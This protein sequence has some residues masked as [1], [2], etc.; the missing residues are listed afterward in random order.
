MVLMVLHDSLA[1]VGLPKFLLNLGLWVGN[2]TANQYSYGDFVMVCN[3][4]YFDRFFYTCDCW[5]CWLL[6]GTDLWNGNHVFDPGICGFSKLLCTTDERVASCAGHYF[7]VWSY[8]WQCTTGTDPL[9]C[10]DNL[11]W[12]FRSQ[13]SLMSNETVLVIII[14]FIPNLFS[15]WRLI[16]FHC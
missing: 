15:I 2:V 4:F 9:F 11:Y 8:G 7:V 6:L 10:A 13:M 1:T 12:I 3:F 14:R 5:D 16:G